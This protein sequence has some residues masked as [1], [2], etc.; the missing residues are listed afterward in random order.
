VLVFYYKIPTLGVCL[1]H[2]AI[3]EFFGGKLGKGLRPMHGKVSAISHFEHPLFNDIP[4]E[5]EVCRYN[6]LII[7]D[8]EDTNLKSIAVSSDGEI[9]ALAHNSLP[10]WAVQFHPEAILTQYGRVIINNWLKYCH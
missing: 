9:M 2:Q 10:L 3:G 5:F 1:G 7:S 4:K 6:S 8:I